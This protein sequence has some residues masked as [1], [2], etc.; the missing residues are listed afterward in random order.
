VSATS[1]ETG[2][3]LMHFDYFNVLVFAAVG[4]V[5]VIV[6]M[7]IGAII[8]PKRKNEEGLEVYE[9]GEPTIGDAWIN[10]DVRYYTVALVY[11]VFAVEIAFLFPWALV[12]QGALKGEGPAGGVGYFA[13]IEGFIFISILF[14]GLAYVWAKGDLS[15]TA[16]YQGEDY[17]PDN[18]SEARSAVPSLSDLQADESEPTEE[19]ETPSD[20][21]E[22]AA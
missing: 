3:P 15:W 2:I 11:L 21:D 22:E 4:F 1:G 5:F 18:P 14:L 6:N 10:F 8:R 20:T 16:E 19:T 7:M 9:C 12:M 17:H 13:L